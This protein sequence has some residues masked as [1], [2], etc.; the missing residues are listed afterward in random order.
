MDCRK[1]QIIKVFVSVLFTVAAI[2]V[3]AST[4]FAAPDADV[5]DIFTPSSLVALQ[6]FVVTVELFNY[7]T[8]GYALLAMYVDGIYWTTFSIPMNEWSYS[9]VDV[10]VTGGLSAGYH[11]IQ[12]LTN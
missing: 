6:T 3:I 4:S 7:G 10:T 2:S 12:Q 1:Y 8:A 11:A 9:W 5:T